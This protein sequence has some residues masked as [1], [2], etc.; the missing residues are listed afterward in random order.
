MAASSRTLPYVKYS[1]VLP[2]SNAMY[3]AQGSFTSRRRPRFHTYR[4]R[5]VIAVYTIVQ[6]L[7]SHRAI[8]MARLCETCVVQLL[9][10]IDAVTAQRLAVKVTALRP[11][12][13]ETRG[14]ELSSISDGA[15]RTRR[16]N[17]Q[18][19]GSAP[20][21]LRKGAGGVPTLPHELFV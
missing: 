8:L 21:R 1:T 3:F 20:P 6:V 16:P 5:T 4:P 13:R 2:D 9:I 19:S 10:Q 11:N 15:A 7:R 17:E 12:S 18:G 14:A